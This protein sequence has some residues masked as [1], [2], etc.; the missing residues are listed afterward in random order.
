[1]TIETKENFERKYEEE[2]PWKIRSSKALTNRL[3][4][5]WKTVPY[6][7][8]EKVIIDCGCGE[9]VITDF[10]TKQFELAVGIDI[11]RKALLRAKENV[12]NCNFI[13]AD[14]R[15]LPFR[16]RSADCITCFETL[17]YLKP[18]YEKALHEFVRILSYRGRIILSI[19]LGKN[20]FNFDAFMRTLTKTVKKSKTFSL[21]VK[22]SCFLG[23]GCALKFAYK[24]A[25]CFPNILARKIIIVCKLKENSQ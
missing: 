22:L 21:Q 2:D 20:Y 25:N 1:M 19:H 17:Y 24:L 23:R 9:G 6:D 7:K 12:R 16:D 18:D 10:I 4:D 8:N 14:L 11:S 15:K 3:E 13:E 5:F